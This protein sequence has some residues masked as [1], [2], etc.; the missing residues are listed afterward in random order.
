MNTTFSRIP[1]EREVSHSGPVNNGGEQLPSQPHNI[2]QVPV[3]ASPTL[4]TIALENGHQQGQGCQDQNPSARR[5]SG[6]RSLMPMKLVP[7]TDLN[8]GDLTREEDYTGSS[9]QNSSDLSRSDKVSEVQSLSPP[10]RVSASSETASTSQVQEISQVYCNSGSLPREPPR[11]TS[12]T[13]AGNANLSDNQRIDLDVQ[14]DGSLSTPRPLRPPQWNPEAYTGLVS[15]QKRTAAGDIKSPS[16]PVVTP[17]VVGRHRSRTIDSASVRTSARAI[18]VCRRSEVPRKTL[19]S[20]AIEGSSPRLMSHSKDSLGDVSVSAPGS[21]TSHPRLHNGSVRV[22][23]RI[24]SS[25]SNPQWALRPSRSSPTGLLQMS[26][27]VPPPNTTTSSEQ[28]HRHQLPNPNEPL[29][30][31][32]TYNP[33]PRHR[34]YYSQQ[35]FSVSNLVSLVPETPL[36]GPSPDPVFQSE[37]KNNTD[38]KRRSRSQNALME[39]DAIETLL[40]M[41]SPGNSGCHPSSQDRDTMRIN[42]NG[43]TETWSNA[44]GSQ[45]QQGSQSEQSQGNWA[46]KS[47]STMLLPNLETQAG[48]EIDRLLDQMDDSDSEDERGFSSYTSS[49][50][51]TS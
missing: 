19:N 37:A 42:T 13:K 41:S 16:S 23:P 25:Y 10:T 4:T 45:T 14:K 18:V 27:L 6:S 24:S 40:F 20:G 22:S 2:A 44:M 35:E 21:P 26:K 32:R 46:R 9:A 1:S 36:L 47:N 49:R 7:V 17:H 31:S 43:S 8:G 11:S 48:D 50:I 38:Y 30:I 28:C 5:C 51:R 29:H 39:Q 15:G 33:S 3:P 34:R 12:S